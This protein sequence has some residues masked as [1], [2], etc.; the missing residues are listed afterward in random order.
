MC[1]YVSDNRPQTLALVV[2][3]E[4]A[5]EPVLALLSHSLGAPGGKPVKL[6]LMQIMKWPST[7]TPPDS[8]LQAI[9][10]AQWSNGK[11]APLHPWTL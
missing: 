2:D 7:Q 10:T 6:G 4:V 5:C 11:Q 3:M 8:S 9:L 1:A